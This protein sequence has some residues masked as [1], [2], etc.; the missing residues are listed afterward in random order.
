MYRAEW[1]KEETQRVVAYIALEEKPQVE[2]IKEPKNLKRPRRREP[3]TRKQII[4]L[5]QALGHT[6]P[7]KIKDMVKKTKMWDENTIKAIDNLTQCEVCAVEHSRLPRPRIAAPR[8]VS[9][10]HIVNNKIRD[11]SRN[12]Y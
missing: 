4:H 10:N 5:H 8:A 1:T 11:S 2:K 9:H 7:D 6:H 3:L 12:N